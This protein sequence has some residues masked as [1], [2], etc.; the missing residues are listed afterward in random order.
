MSEFI[1]QWNSKI[2]NLNIIAGA[3]AE[4]SV[5]TSKSL[6]AIQL[7]SLFQYDLERTHEHPYY[8]YYLVFSPMNKPYEA[9]PEWFEFKGLD[10]VRSKYSNY[11]AYIATRETK[12]TK[13]HINLLILTQQDLLKQ[14]GKKCFH[15]Y[16][17]HAQK[18]GLSPNNRDAVLSYMTKE[19]QT[20]YAV[21]YLDYNL[22]HTI[23]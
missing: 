15:K 16:H 4:A 14:N 3:N 20:K 12:A 23:L 8:W 17:I 2:G 1:D 7:K 21:K 5:T 10:K 19:F 6:T 18:L 9:D 13:T 11:L 22:C